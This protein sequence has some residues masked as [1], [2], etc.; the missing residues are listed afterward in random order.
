[1]NESV[2]SKVEHRKQNINTPLMYM[3][4]YSL[5]N[6]ILNSSMNRVM[7]V[8]RVIKRV[9]AKWLIKCSIQT[10]ISHFFVV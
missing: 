4:N 7:I 5:I 6:I 1:M 10:K 9:N 2:S 8:L 3:S